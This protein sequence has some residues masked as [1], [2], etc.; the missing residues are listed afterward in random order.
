MWRW[1]IEGQFA[2]ERLQVVFDGGAFGVCRAFCLE[3]VGFHHV[4]V[5]VLRNPAH[6]FG[7]FDVVFKQ[8][9]ESKTTPAHVAKVTNVVVYH[10]R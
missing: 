5:G 4:G 8:I 2:G 3:E 6:V 1:P 7:L 9:A 10:L